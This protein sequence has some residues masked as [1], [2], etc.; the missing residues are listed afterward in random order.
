MISFGFLRRPRQIESDE[1][2]ATIVETR[3]RARIARDCTLCGNH[4][5]AMKGPE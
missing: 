2:H 5:V 3:Q 1:M 4:V